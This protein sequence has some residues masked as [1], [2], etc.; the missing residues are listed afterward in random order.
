MK[1]LKSTALIYIL[2][3]AL[4]LSGCA[5]QGPGSVPAQTGKEEGSSPEDEN[6]KEEETGPVYYYDEEYAA[7]EGWPWTDYSVFRSMDPALEIS[8]KDNFYAAVNKDWLTTTPLPDGYGS[9]DALA[10]QQVKVKTS[11]MDLIEDRS[12]SAPDL[13]MARAYYDLFMDWEG[14][15]EQ[16]LEPLKEII[17]PLQEAETLEEM[18]EYIC[19]YDT[20]LAGIQP[21][22]F[23]VSTDLEDSEWNTVYLGPGP[24]LLDDPGYYQQMDDGD[25]AYQ[26]IYT[27]AAAGILQRLGYSPKEAERAVANCFY[28]EWLISESMM[29]VEESYAPDAI[30]RMNNH[31]TLEEIREAEGDFPAAEVLEAAG[32]GKSDRYILLEPEWLEAMADIYSLDYMEEIRDYMI[33]ND[34]ITY[35]TLLDREAYDAYYQTINSINEIDGS[36]DDKEAAYNAMDK[37]MNLV[38]AQVYF[39][40]FGDEESKKEI[41]DLIDKIVAYYR[42]MLE[43]EDFLSEKT[44]ERAVEKLDALRVQAAYPEEDYDFGDASILPPSQGGTLM[45]AMHTI[46][47]VNLN[48]ELEMINQKTDPDEWSFPSHRVNAAYDSSQNS[49]CITAA[50]LGGSYYHKDMTPEELYGGI[51]TIIGHEISHAFDTSGALY[52]KDGCYKNWWEEEDYTAFRKRADDLISYFDEIYPNNWTKCSGELVDTEAIADLCGVKCMLAMARDIEDFDY[53]LFFKSY[54]ANWRSLYTSNIQ[55]FAASQDSHPLNYLRVNVILQQFDEF[56]D[57]YGITEGDGMYLAPEDRLVI[58]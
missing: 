36:L 3:A 2:A 57:T 46:F 52:D 28:F 6:T 47:E 45:Q 24:L 20:I 26:P 11:L 22:T 23:Y 55:Y 14:R 30:E 42:T 33:V 37:Y 29:S 58:W 17:G 7:E 10:E 35:M 5:S 41:T 43:G 40:N 15:N 49:I 19:S 54:A 56:Y 4:F 51:G 48:S 8:E 18:S 53:D 1:R 21:L 16:G 39:H 32:M 27:E 31:V 9:W 34:I 38:L 44:V 50:I 12:V 25:Y 13:D